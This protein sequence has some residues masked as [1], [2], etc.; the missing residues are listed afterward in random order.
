MTGW[1]AED[2]DLNGI[3]YAGGA[4]FDSDK[5]CLP[6]TREQILE[7]I[8]QWINSPNDDGMPRMYFLTG[9]AGSGKSA[10]AH[11]IAMRFDQL[12]R[13]G[14]S[15]Y[16][17]RSDQSRRPNNLF[18]TISLDIAD[19]DDQ[20]KASLHRV[21]RG[22]RALRSTQGVSDQFDA[23]MLEPAEALSAVGPV[24]VVIDALDES[25]DR[26]SREVLL[27]IL[28]GKLRDL[29]SNFRFLVTSRPEPDIYDALNGSP[30][31]L[32]QHMDS[33]SRESN[34]AD[35]RL[36][37]RTQLLGIP[38]LEE[39][40]PGEEWCRLLLKSSDGLFQWAYTA[41]SAIKGGQFGLSVAERL[42][43]F[44]TSA[45]GLD[46]L[47]TE[48]LSQVFDTDNLLVM[49]RFRSIMGRILAVKE[50]LSLASLSELR[51]ENEPA[52]LVGR[53]VRPLASLLSG[54]NQDDAAVRPLHTSFRD[55]LTCEERSTRFYVDLSQPHQ[56]L[57]LAF[58][59]VM[60]KE[61]RF[62]ICDLE[63]SHIKN[64]NVDDLDILVAKHI[65]GH[66]SYACRFWATHAQGMPVE[67]ATLKIVEGFLYEKF[68]QWLEVLS[69]TQSVP[70]ASSSLKL[71][72]EW[73]KVTPVDLCGIPCIDTIV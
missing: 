49:N 61:L 72:M 48:I 64:A 52:G 28:S 51:C 24:V 66:L 34:D 8:T 27:R 9:T 29:P 26:T 55:F 47:Y 33:I 19:L 31:V 46:G 11:T 58:W 43:V 21:I 73:I 36:Y 15:F 25:G 65:P 3:P 17:N 13:L 45:R 70:S 2:V 4:R 38:D 50:P 35:I 32:C 68:L 6:G 57:A 7:E 37:I 42:A 30:H 59:R 16:F 53:I 69:L 12:G 5:G 40:W 22:K 39:E 1:A 54:V 41:C 10:I 14:S 20:W 63:T 44:I 18:S 60:K 23:F 71:C 62:N 56:N 67:P